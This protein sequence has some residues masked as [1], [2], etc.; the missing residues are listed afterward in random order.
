MTR[1]NNGTIIVNMIKRYLEK[2]VK[3][4]LNDNMVT[5]L[6]GARQVGKTTLAKKILNS[7]KS[8]L[9]LDCDDPTIIRNIQNA[10]LHKLK[11]IVNNYD[12][13]VIDEAQRVEN[14]GLTAKLIHDNLPEKKLLLTGSSSLDL[15][16][17]VK[18]PL[19]GRSNELML[20][21]VAIKELAENTLK[22]E[23]ILPTL[24]IY[25]GYPGLW[26]ISPIKASKMA[27]NI[28]NN[29]IYKDAFA[30]NTIYDQTVLNN[31]LRL[32]AHQIGNEVSYSELAGHLEVSKETIMR[33]IDLLEKAF[34]IF[35]RPQY[36]KNKRSL[37]GRLRKIYFYDLG[38]RNAL[39]DDFRD[40]E[41][42]SDVGQLWENL[43][44]V[45]R[46]KLHQKK[47]QYT[48]SYYWRSRDKQE[49]DLIEEISTTTLAFECKFK[50]NAKIPKGFVNTYPEIPFKVISKDNYWDYI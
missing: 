12:L 32:L 33:Y 31:L 38:I 27:R 19:T 30:L 16:N 1:D 36:R 23:N 35:R 14:I 5:V 48:R 17:K 41:F 45:E 2:Q 39:I 34:I 11:S 9:Y 46:L 24:M 26:G 4:S 37:I 28:A 15:A 6:Y 10:S 40:L 22:A 50:K 47:E 21:P 25:G 43:I 3:E 8:G 18:E 44:L 49:V 13:I 20:Y 42:R 29:Y 7:S